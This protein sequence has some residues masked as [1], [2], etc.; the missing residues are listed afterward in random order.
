MNLTCRVCYADQSHSPKNHFAHAF[1]EV[2]SYQ[3]F[4]TIMA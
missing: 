4:Y 2:Q 3:M 1:N